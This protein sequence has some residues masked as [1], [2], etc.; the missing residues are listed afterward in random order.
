MNRTRR[1]AGWIAAAVLVAGLLVL[2]HALHLDQLVAD[3]R[4]W[5]ESQGIAGALMFA[6]LYAVCSLLLVPATVLTIAAGAI[7]GLLWG[8][9]LSWC[10]A[11]VSAVVAFLIARHFARDRVER[12]VRSR[13]RLRAV[14]HAIGDGGFRV[15][16]LLRLSPIVPFSVSNYVYGVTP[17]RA[18][19]YLAASAL[20]M[21]PGT[22]LYVY[23][24]HLGGAAAAGE[25]GAGLWRWVLLV[26]GLL[27]TA[28]AT[29]FIAKR[30]RAA[31][32]TRRRPAG[33]RP[34]ARKHP[35]PSRSPARARTQKR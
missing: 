28:V 1:V 35:R 29:I 25:E 30:A 22:F 4:R 26:A 11:M 9:V 3:L 2:G 33:R 24:G 17:V 12:A 6:A 21:L 23:L 10:A 14:D 34:R 31:L 18:G 19:S 32:H 7:F 8:S 13:P 5:V 16:A 27:A 15:V 20:G